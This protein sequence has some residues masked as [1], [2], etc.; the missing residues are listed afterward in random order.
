MQVARREKKAVVLTI[1][2]SCYNT[3]P[4]GKMC[5]LVQ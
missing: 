5:P 3:G 4:L 1:T 2:V